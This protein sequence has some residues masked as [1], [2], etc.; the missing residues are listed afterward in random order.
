MRLQ[1]FENRLDDLIKEFNDVSCEDLAD[2]LEY[3]SV[4]TRVKGK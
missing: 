3:F 4:K 2:S 1:Q